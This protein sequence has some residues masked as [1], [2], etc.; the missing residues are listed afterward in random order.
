MIFLLQKSYRKFYSNEGER[1]TLV[2][3]KVQLY[4]KDV[5]PV[6]FTESMEESKESGSFDGTNM[7]SST[8]RDFKDGGKLLTLDTIE[9]CEVQ[10]FRGDIST[11][12][13]V[14]NAKESKESV[15]WGETSA[16]RASNR[17][18]KDPA[19]SSEFK[20]QNNAFEN[21][22]D[23]NRSGKQRDH[24]DQLQPSGQDTVASQVGY[25]GDETCDND[26]SAKDLLSFAW[27][28]AQGMVSSCR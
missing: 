15:V 11:V 28:V 1:H 9:A 20:Y 27:Q 10:L 8:N 25:H 6:V 12:M 5:I 13:S 19:C 16:D 14:R 22:E 21:D 7:N 18:P 4:A 26:F 23:G 2:A 3:E 24:Y 17:G